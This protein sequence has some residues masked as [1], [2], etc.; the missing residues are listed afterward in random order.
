[1]RVHGK[2]VAFTTAL[3]LVII[4]VL[5]IIA[6]PMLQVAI[7]LLVG[8]VPEK[9]ADI[10][11]E[12]RPFNRVPAVRATGSSELQANPRLMASAVHGYRG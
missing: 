8:T 9:V 7:F 3:L 4:L 10:E 2:H 1:M 11:M 12:A 6:R 5:R